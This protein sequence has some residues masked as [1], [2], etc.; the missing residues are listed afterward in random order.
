MH[1]LRDQDELADFRTVGHLDRWTTG[2]TDSWTH[3][4]LDFWQAKVQ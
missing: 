4:P 2:P 1:I 3:G